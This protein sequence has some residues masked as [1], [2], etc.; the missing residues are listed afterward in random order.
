MPCGPAAVVSET[1]PALVVLDCLYS[2]PPPDSFLFSLL[3]NSHTRVVLVA[4]GLPVE[5]IVR[6]IDRRLVRGCNVTQVRE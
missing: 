5:R 4:T 6:E 2:L 1:S 3:Q